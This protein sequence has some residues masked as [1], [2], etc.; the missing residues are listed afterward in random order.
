VLV[1]GLAEG[2]YNLQFNYEVVRG[3]WVLDVR[4]K[5]VQ[6]FKPADP[7]GWIFFGQGSD[8]A[9]R[10]VRKAVDRANAKTAAAASQPKR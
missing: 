6:L 9:D 5:T 7:A 4:E 10:L 8:L 2:I 1:L 3:K